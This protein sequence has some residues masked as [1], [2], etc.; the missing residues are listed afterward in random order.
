MT[1][2]VTWTASALDEL[3]ELWKTTLPIA[4]KWTD[5]ANRIDSLL[6]SHP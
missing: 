2:T 1:Y 5:A 4:R 3:A 6:R